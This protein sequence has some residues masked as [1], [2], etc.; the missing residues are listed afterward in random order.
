MNDYKLIDIRTA[1]ILTNAYVAG[2]LISP[3]NMA[4]TIAQN[5][6]LL[7]IDFTL[8]SLTDAQ[9]KIEFSNDGITYFQECSGL[10]SAGVETDSLLVHKLTGTGKF[11]IPVQ[12]KDRF[13]KISV[14][15]T[16]TVTSSSMAIKAV[17]GV[18]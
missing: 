13:I 15:G 18:A 4:Y 11:R 1:A 6:L 16:G 17:M 10:V 14:I 7:Y 2:T 3:A 9:I 8:G 5:E 12:I